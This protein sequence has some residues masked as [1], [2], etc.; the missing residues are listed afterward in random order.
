MSNVA[1]EL[2]KRKGQMSQR[3]LANYLGISQAHVSDILNGKYVPGLS[4]AARA[5]LRR[6]PDMLSVFLPAEIGTAI[7]ETAGR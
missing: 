7:Q 3:E 5:I 6:F 2:A 4:P 1:E